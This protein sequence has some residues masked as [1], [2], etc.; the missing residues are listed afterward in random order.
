[1]LAMRRL[2]ENAE[3]REG[4]A[5]KKGGRRERRLNEESRKTGRV[6]L[7]SSAFPSRDCGTTFLIDLS[8]SLHSLRVFAAITPGFRF[9]PP[10][11][12]GTWIC[13]KASSPV[14]GPVQ[15]S[16]QHGLAGRSSTTLA[17]DPNSSVTDFARSA[18]E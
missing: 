2:N 10:A 1:L 4:M 11:T 3:G 7:P 17:L 5:C 9:T 13:R 8:R 15:A 6:K 16:I 12:A 18:S 14:S